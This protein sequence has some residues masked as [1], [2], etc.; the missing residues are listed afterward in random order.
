MSNFARYL[1]PPSQL[2]TNSHPA[3]V[4]QLRRTQFLALL[5][6][7]GGEIFLLLAQLPL[8]FDQFRGLARL[9]VQILSVDLVGGL[10]GVVP[11]NE[12]FEL[13]GVVRAER[14]DARFDPGEIRL[15]GFSS[16]SDISRNRFWR[17]VGRKVL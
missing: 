1:W 9:L 10:G 2:T 3:D 7:N 5:S 12:T 17:A 4:L 8:V 15:D 6:Q 16:L 11:L 14:V 13:L